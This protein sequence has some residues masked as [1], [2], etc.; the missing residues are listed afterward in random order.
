MEKIIVYSANINGYDDLVTPKIFDSNVEYILFTDDEAF[1]SNVWNIKSIDFV[2]KN[3]DLRK[4]SRYM[5]LNPHKVLPPHDISIWID[6]CFE[7]KFSN[8][9]EMLEQLNFKGFNVMSYKHPERNCIYDEANA[10]LKYSLDSVEV[11]S[12]QMKR[13][14]SVGYPMN[15]GL[16]ENGFIIR[17]NKDKVNFFN[18]TWWNEVKNNSGRDQLSHMYA[19]WFTDVR[20][21]PIN[22]GV[23]MSDNPFLNKKK[24]HKK[25][26]I[27]KKRLKK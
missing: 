11:V 24:Q 8:V 6:H 2:D 22:V 5:K 23:S 7:P 13:Y 1:K 12:N 10:V 25:G 26:F 9:Q 27:T 21:N 16:F 15:Y 14:I 18:E 19:S 20:I 4:R 3:L 17:R